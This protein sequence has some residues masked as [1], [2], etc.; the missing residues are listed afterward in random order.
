MSRRTVLVSLLSLPLIYAGG[1]FADGGVT[2]TDIAAGGGAGLSYGRTASESFSVIEELRTR[3]VLRS[4]LPNIPLFPTGTPGVA[5]LDYDRDGDQDLYVTNGPGTPNSLF[6][7]QLRETGQ[8]TFVD[9]ALAAGVG[10][11]DQDSLGVCAGDVDNDGD[12]DLLV[13]GSNESNRFFVN[14]GNGTFAD[15]TWASGLG[16]GRRTSTS[17][18]FGDVNLDGLLDVLVANAFNNW[19]HQRVILSPFTYNEHNQLFINQG[20]NRFV[21]VSATSGIQNLSELPAALAGSASLT[22]AI[23]LVDIDQDGDVDIVQGDD[24]ELPLP[25]AAFGGIDLGLLRVFR[26][27]GTGH[28]TD[29]SREAGTNKAGVWMGMSYGDL[30]CDGHLDIFATNGG[31]YVASLDG[32]PVGS[33]PSEWFLGQADGTFQQP[34]VGSLVATPFGWGT[35]ML[36]YDN[37][38]DTDIIFHGGFDQTFAADASNPGALLRNQ[39]C[40]ASFVYDAEALAGSTNHSLRAEFGV[41]AGDLDNNGFEDI[42]SASSFDLPATVTLIPYATLFGS[43]FDATAWRARFFNSAGVPGQLIWNGVEHQTGT[44]SVELNSGNNGNNWAAIQLVGTKGLIANRHSRGKVNRDGIGAVVK[45]TPAGGQS[46]LTPIVAG[47]SYG[48]Q[49]SLLVNVGLGSATN[50]VVEVLW[51]GGVRNRLYGVSASENVVLPEIPCSFTTSLKKN[52]YAK[53]VSESLKDLR[54]PRVG[55]LTKAQADRL[56][57]SALRAY[58]ESH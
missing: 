36:D 15:R 37:D 17:C 57:A 38:G 40:S 8:A 32:L 26:N 24:Q 9:V 35:S 29:V 1:A 18:S 14:R 47:S 4:E 27:D 39:G 3:V 22:W 28:F 49:D 20:G 7:N 5:I 46:T 31:D 52:E 54:R 58:E 30:N 55:M 16:G 25:P 23:S 44:L 42:V 50:G 45:F 11:A 41:A 13:L 53:C 2:F 21:D 43:P 33:A 56:E 10:A 51:P 48:S 19:S 12:Q 6:S 34:G